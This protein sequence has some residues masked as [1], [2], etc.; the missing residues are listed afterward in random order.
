MFFGHLDVLKPQLK[1]QCVTLT[2]QQRPLEPHMVNYSV[3]LCVPAI[4]W[5]SEAETQLNNGYYP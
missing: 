1:Q 3:G 5:F 4:M 2:D